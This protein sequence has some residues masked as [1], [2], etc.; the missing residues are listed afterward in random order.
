MELWL[1]VIILLLVVIL[2]MQSERF[3]RMN[4]EINAI[5]R[6]LDLLLERKKEQSS[7]VETK[8][9]SGLPEAVEVQNISP[10]FVAEE[11]LPM[12]EAENPNDILGTEEL[13]SEEITVVEG[14]L[15]E[16]MEPDPVV[17]KQTENLKSPVAAFS[18]TEKKKINYEKF[19]GENL[20]G[21]VGILVLVVGIGL[22]VKYA[23]DKDWINETMRTIL[24]FV[25]GSILLFIAERVQKRYRTFSSLL[26]GGAFAVF[27][28]TVAIAFHYY[29]LFSQTTAFVMLVFITLLM[30]V[31]AILYDRRELAVIALVGGFIAPFLVSSG[32]GS[33]IVLFTYLTILNLGMFGLSLYKKWEELPIISF[34][35]TYLVFLIYVLNRLMFDY[36]S[37]IEVSIQVKYLFVFASL[38]YFIF[39]LPVLSILKSERKKLNKCLLSVIIANNFIY[40]FLGI[41]FIDRMFLPVKV[42]GAFTLFI[43]VVN[44][45]LVIWLRKSRKDYKFL[46]YTMLGLVLTF[47][48]ITIPIQLDGNYITLLWASEMVLLL[49]LYVKSEIRVYEYASLILVGLTFISYIMDVGHQ[50]KVFHAGD[51]IFINSMFATSL[52]TGLATGA[53]ALLIARYRHSFKTARYLGYIPWN[54]VMLISSVAILYYTFMIEFYHYLSP[55]ISYKVMHLFTSCCI[56]ILCYGFRKRFPVGDYALFYKMGIGI[57]VVLYLFC[58]WRNAGVTEGVLSVLFPWVTTIAVTGNL[59]Y[60]GWLYRVNRGIVPRFIVY[61]GV[62]STLFWLAI[63][64]LFLHQLGL[65]DEFN[66]GFSIAL[67]IAGFVQM[68]LGMRFHQKV[69]RVLSLVTLGIVLIKLVLVDLWAMPTVGK[70]AVFIMLGVILLVLSF[71]YQKLKDVL[72]KDDEQIN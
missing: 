51:I 56:L 70:I 30:S 2:Y 47:V 39:L 42:T 49:W 40:L 5:K 22:F 44:L 38:F 29:H 54:A 18:K 25:A 57:S 59:V 60:V 33:Y 67:A 4:S 17:I 58:A 9:T 11:T 43:A 62:I 55:V 32:E 8:I 68:S 24:G 13:V 52:F 71:L 31:L 21:K 35:A 48:S 41:L 72:F 27:Y 19:I 28:L 53:Y 3:A 50:M 45:A 6:R 15:L 34:V 36:Q 69:L 23:I 1:F 46:I 61:L 26:A 16:A 12:S 10:V 65:P 63:V 7:T 20:F 66:A 14:A 64:R 37:G